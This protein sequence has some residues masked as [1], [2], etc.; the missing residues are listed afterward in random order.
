MLQAMP[1]YVYFGRGSNCYNKPGTK[2]YRSIIKQYAQEFHR[3]AKKSQKS[4]FIDNVWSHL[5]VQGFRFVVS[6]NSEDNQV[7]WKEASILEVKKR[8]GHALR[9]HRK[10]HTGLKTITNWKSNSQ[11]ES[12]KQ[13]SPYIN[14]NDALNDSVCDESSMSTLESLLLLG[15][16]QDSFQHVVNFKGED[17]S[18]GWCACKQSNDCKISKVSF[19]DDQE[20]S[21]EQEDVSCSSLTTSDVREVYL[22]VDFSDFAV[23]NASHKNLKGNKRLLYL[24]LYQYLFLNLTIPFLANKYSFPHL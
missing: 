9:D 2:K 7:I 16:Q 22:P 21:T 6:C 17:I 19:S 18:D 15:D 14:T 20:C 10:G 4:A 23:L 11:A 13:S 12:L 5:Y 8:I 3:N 24:Y 1:I